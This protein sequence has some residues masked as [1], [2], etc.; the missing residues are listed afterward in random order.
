MPPGTDR[1][2]SVYQTPCENNVAVGVRVE[3]QPGLFPTVRLRD[4][5]DVF[6]HERK[7]GS[8]VG[9]FLELAHNVNAEF[10]RLD[11]PLLRLS[12]EPRLHAGVKSLI[13]SQHFDLA[14]NFPRVFCFLYAR[15]KQIKEHI[16]AD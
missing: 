7:A 1:F 8:S 4:V 9:S 16:A 15:G 2:E 10:S 13:G 3:A 12:E 5:S 14:S 11:S 6:V